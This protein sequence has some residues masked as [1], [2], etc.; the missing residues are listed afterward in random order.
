MG[1]STSSPTN[2]TENNSQTVPKVSKSY[3]TRDELMTHYQEM[4]I[5][6]LTP[7]ELISFKRSVGSNI[8]VNDIYQTELLYER[9]HLPKNNHTLKKII[10]SIFVTLANFP[11][12]NEINPN[13][14]AG[15]VLKCIVM[16]TNRSK[17]YISGKQTGI[18]HLLFIGLS[19]AESTTHSTSKEFLNETYNIT[20]VLSTYDN[21][22]F[23]GITVS[24]NTLLHFVSWL[25]TLRYVV[26][27]NNCKIDNSYNN[28][29]WEAFENSA[30]SIIRSMNPKSFTSSADSSSDTVTFDE[31]IAVFNVIVP[32][33]TAPLENLIEH[34]LYREDDLV[35]VTLPLDEMEGSKMLTKSLYT[36]IMASLP[37][38][39]VIS[40]L[41]KLYVGRESGFSMRSLQAKVFKWLAP[42]IIIV[43][44]MRIV[45]DTLYTEKK[46]PRYKNF[47]DHYH[48]LR[49]D[50]QHLEDCFQLKR[51][52]TFA[53]YIKEPWKVTNKSSFGGE[54]TTIIQLSPRQDIYRANTS[55]V[56]YFNTLGGGIGIGCNQP[57]VKGNL[58]QHQPG[59]VSLT[60][61]NALEFAAFR[62]VGYGGKINPSV[63]QT[64]SDNLDATF[65]LRF[66]ISDL[67]VWGCGGEK[68][69]EEQMKQLKWE[70]AEAKRRQHINL[71][72]L[73]EDRALL[74]MAGLVGQ[75]QS[76]G[77][78]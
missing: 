20:E 58:E 47:L 19:K 15:G 50:D 61:D 69:L 45:D 52:V 39:I 67:E 30:K 33:I 60:I 3:F 11:I 65:E 25:L 2:A 78:V 31:F 21:T 14:T 4:A 72:S 75:H 64:E 70:E 51:K 36:Q 53:I 35:E 16:L 5:K 17:K 38:D 57:T 77:S 40:K 62:H 32:N 44:G 63:L 48:I 73:G 54:H 7:S 8:E 12:V 66:S 24:S 49:E 74:E 71:K 42:T 37:N 9:L 29:D 1:Q 41:Q 59:N 55:D 34:L 76:G 10:L 28:V 6:L 56:I 46:N 68:E 43:S 26:P 27:S 22:N 23:D 18:L 13:L